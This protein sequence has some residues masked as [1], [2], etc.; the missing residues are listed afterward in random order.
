MTDSV[1]RLAARTMNF[2]LGVPRAFQVSPDGARVFFLR[3]VSGTSRSHALYVHDVASGSER[4]LADPADL[5]ADEEQLTPTERARR[6]R[7]RISSSGIVSFSVDR[8]G[9]TVAFTLSS[10][11]FV[12]D[13]AHGEPRE[14]PTSAAVLVPRI[15]PTG[16]RVA[17]AGDRG[18][19][20]VDLTSG[21][22]TVLV[23]PDPSE[24]DDVV[25][26]LAEFIAGEELDRGEGF[27]WAPDGESLLVERYDESPVAVWHISDPAFPERPPARVRYPQCG[28]AN[29]VVGLAVV[30]LTGG[31]VDVDWRS[32]TALDGHV[33]EYLAHVGWDGPQPV[34]TLLT[35]D[36][37]RLEYRTVDVAG[38]A[39]RLLRAVTDDAYVELVPGTPRRLD[40]GRLLHSVDVGETRRLYLDDEPFTPP[41]VLVREVLAVEDDAVLAQVVSGV[42]SVA[43]ARLGFDGGVELLSDDGGVASAAVGG[44]TLVLAQE[45]P[46]E[47]GTTTT[48]RAGGTATATATATAATIASVAEVSPLTPVLHTEA[49]GPHELHTT[50]LFPTGHV[51]GSRRLPILLDPYGGPH[52][53]R[54]VSSARAHLVSQWFAD[55][56]FAVVVCDG[57][58]TPGRGPAW[59]RLARFDRA[60]TADDQAEA[61][62]LVA[63]RFPDDVDAG[64]VGIRGW[65][66]GGYL[67][68]LCVLRHP[69]V[70]HAAVA[71]APTTDERLYDTCYS[72]RYLG[73]PDEH[74]HVYEANSLVPLAPQLR[75]P[76]MIIHGLADDNVYV[77]H[78]LRLSS[79]LLAAGRPHE[80]LPLTGIT[81]LAGD[82]VVAENLLL[83]QLDFLRR[84]LGG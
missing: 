62:G 60:G 40:D 83:L 2:R 81:H 57:R 6:E 45:G 46:H 17:Y 84:S 30:S 15:D 74:P 29:A 33:L 47:V 24:P 26:G 4:L 34:L 23:A 18:L 20:V 1:P 48:V 73:H 31:R 14:L 35:R 55:Q 64:R 49:L 43:V 41:A 71:G 68:A 77:A 7:M 50:V 9:R 44:D 61:V 16:R 69:D 25:W 51:P 5:L 53:Q 37:Q 3:A 12:V 27:W 32:D 19:H 22:D 75:R 54:V 56:G 13:A 72:E 79:A 8:E 10:R 76:L 63:A 65:S 11:L 59:E 70:I 21:Q 28:T 38:G 58:G 39:T 36:Q 42:G 78:S 67:A 80:V 66:F 82:E 52:G